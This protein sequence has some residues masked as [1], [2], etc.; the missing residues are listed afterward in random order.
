MSVPNTDQWP[1]G[2]RPSE[3]DAYTYEQ[4]AELMAISVTLVERFVSLN[5]VEPQEARLC[6]RDLARIAQMLRLRRDLGLNWVGAG[7]V[8]DMCQEIAQLKARL[9]AYGAPVD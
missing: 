5:L 1:A 9:R 6:D 2:P 7:M 4:T 8:L 3:D